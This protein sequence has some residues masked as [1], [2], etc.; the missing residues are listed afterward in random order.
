M[1]ELWDGESADESGGWTGGD[2]EGA[3]GGADALQSGYSR[4]DALSGAEAGSSLPLRNVADVKIS[5]PEGAAVN[6]QNVGWL[7]EAAV[8]HGMSQRQLDAVV[9]GY[10]QFTEQASAALKVQAESSLKKEYGARYGEVMA[11][12]G[13]ACR[14]FNHMTGGEFSGL[15]EAGLGNHPG[16]IKFMIAVSE[17]VSDSA[18]PGTPK[19]SGDAAVSTGA[20]LSE[21]FARRAAGA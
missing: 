5:T 14:M 2:P 7:K 8:A 20:F 11:R 21:I 18:L 10:N 19:G 17:A 1:G 15:I 3:L 13:D 16:F 4:P 6:E 9:Q 12:A